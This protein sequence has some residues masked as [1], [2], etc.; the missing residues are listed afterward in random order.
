MTLINKVYFQL[1]ISTLDAYI[2]TSYEGGEKKCTYHKQNEK[3]D[4]NITENLKSN[5]KIS[6]IKVRISSVWLKYYIKMSL[7]FY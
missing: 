3:D 7:C 5:I 4:F 6:T 1:I 2:V